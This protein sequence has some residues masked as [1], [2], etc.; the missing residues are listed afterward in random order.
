MIIE[1]EKWSLLYFFRY[2]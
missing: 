1:K 2:H